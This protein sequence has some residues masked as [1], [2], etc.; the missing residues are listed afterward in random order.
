MSALN[1]LLHFGLAGLL[2]AA[3]VTVSV[4]AGSPMYKGYEIPDFIV[5]QSDGPFELREY[6]PHLVAEVKVSGERGA[7]IRR[8]FRTLAGFIFGKNADETKI[9]M[10]APVTQAETDGAWQ[11]QF[12]MPAG[13]NLDSLPKPDNRDIRFRVTPVE[14]QAVVQ[15]PGFWTDRKL[16]AK[17]AELRQWIT[18]QGL[19]VAD[20]PR[21]YFYDDPFTLPMRRRNEVAFLVN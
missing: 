20:G 10:T 1:K 18:A 5:T 2:V 19:Q 7:A 6:E 4:Q 3:A 8:G 16:A 21:Y 12:V 17:S 9:A 14:K 13:Y 15:F 11:V